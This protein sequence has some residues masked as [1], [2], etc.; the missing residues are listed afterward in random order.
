MINSSY[1]IALIWENRKLF[2][3]N[4]P[5]NINKKKKTTIN[6]LIMRIT[7]KKIYN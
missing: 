5:V 6:L 3:M 1:Q 7:I 2:F 4:S